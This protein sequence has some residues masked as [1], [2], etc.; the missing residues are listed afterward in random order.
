MPI[1][2]PITGST[3]SDN[4]R[5]VE[6]EAD[7]PPDSESN[8]KLNEPEKMVEKRKK[9]HTYVWRV[10]SFSSC[11]KKCGG[12]N[13]SPIIRCVREGTSKFFAHKRCAHQTK[14]VL[15]EAVLRCNT[16]PCPAYWKVDEWSACNCGLPNEHDYQTRHIKCVQ[17]LSAGVVINVNEGACLDKQ[18]EN[19]QE[20]DCPKQQSTYYRNSNKGK[21][22]NH[23]HHQHH[24]SSPITLIGN[25]TIGKKAHVL[26]GRKPGVWL[27]S[28]W[29]DQVRKR[30]MKTPYVIL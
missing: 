17:E 21:D 5:S 27:A 28:D 6:M 7:M 30:H 2:P 16:Q 8:V 23:H 3:G 19:R 26:E 9:K 11:S 24:H 13:L 1:N 10:V 14:P 20:C 15:N 4:P 25:S 12:G 22:K 18:P 29:N